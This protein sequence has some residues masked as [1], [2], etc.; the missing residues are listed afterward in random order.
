MQLHLAMIRF[1]NAVVDWVDDVEPW[2]RLTG[3]ERGVFER[4]SQLVR[5]H[6]QWL[7]V[8]DYLRTLTKAACL[9]RRSCATR[10]SSRP[11][12]PISMPLEFAVAAFQS[13]TG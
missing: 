1:H 3:G 7:V 11:R 8:N 6:Y 2:T 13:G 10:R 4:A 9:T 5:W 12:Y